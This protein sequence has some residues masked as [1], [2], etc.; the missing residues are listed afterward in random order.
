MSKIV[1]SET[2]HVEVSIN[3]DQMIQKMNCTKF[4][5]DCWFR[6]IDDSEF[7]VTCPLSITT[8]ADAWF[9]TTKPFFFLCGQ[10][11]RRL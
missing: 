1:N 7:S 10:Q 11:Q 8:H 3:L 4:S 5:I 9:Y 6:I 2:V